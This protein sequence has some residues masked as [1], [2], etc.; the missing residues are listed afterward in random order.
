MSV[1]KRKYHFHII[2]TKIISTHRALLV[3]IITTILGIFVSSSYLAINGGTGPFSSLLQTNSINRVASEEDCGTGYKWDDIR[4]CVRTNNPAVTKTPAAVIK[5]PAPI[6]TKQV[7]PCLEA[8]KANIYACNACKSQTANNPPVVTPSTS[9]TSAKATCEKQSTSTQSCTYST[10]CKCTAITPVVTTPP[11]VCNVNTGVNIEAGKYAATGRGLDANGAVCTQNGCPSRECVQIKADCSH[12]PSVKCHEQN[13]AQPGSVIMPPSAG[14][15]YT[16]GMTPAQAK[17]AEKIALAKGQKLPDKPKEQCYDK[18]SSGTWVI[19]VDGTRKSSDSTQ[20]CGD[21]DWKPVPIESDFAL[22]LTKAEQD[23]IKD[24]QIACEAGGKEFVGGQCITKN[25]L[26][27]VIT[28]CSKELGST[29]DLTTGICVK[30]PQ[31]VA[32]PA[33]KLISSSNCNTEQIIEGQKVYI[34]C[35]GAFSTVKFCT[36]GNFDANHNCI[37]PPAASIP[38][39]AS[40]IL[41]ISTIAPVKLSSSVAVP[42]DYLNQMNYSEEKVRGGGTWANSGCGVMAGAMVFSLVDGKADPYEYNK[43]LEQH[44]GVTSN[45]TGWFDQHKVILEENNFEV[46][47]VYGSLAEKEKQIKEYSKEGVP[48][49]INAYIENGAGN[50]IGHHTLAVGVDPVSGDLILDDPY[51]GEGYHMPIDRIDVDCSKSG[52]GN[53]TS[54]WIMNAIIPPEVIK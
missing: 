38:K 14:P 9:F 5:T 30:N 29:I 16:S 36:G 34:D 33:N 43:L 32:P 2:H 47:P 46:V 26:N 22:N 27:A 10:T 7:D 18:S 25:E 53:G 31:F 48:V 35:T 44:G 41:P 8:C 20:Y 13:A 11:K 39:V 23:R 6:P 40:T 54:S 24:L 12:G 49:W 28:S 37:L 51:Y 4:G 21:G 42:I 1:K 17:E 15:E 19:V 50:W 45:G 3:L 52:C